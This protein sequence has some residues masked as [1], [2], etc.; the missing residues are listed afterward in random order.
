MKSGWT[1][2]FSHATSRLLFELVIGEHRKQRSNRV[3]GK[4]VHPAYA[5]PLNVC[6]RTL[7]APATPSGVPAKKRLAA[8]WRWFGDESAY[9]RPAGNFVTQ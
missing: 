5:T 1:P 7:S 3:D 8:D 4:L 9:D 6:P 2:A